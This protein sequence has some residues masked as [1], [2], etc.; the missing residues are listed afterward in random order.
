MEVG[1]EVG[2]KL[3]RMTAP[4]EIFISRLAEVPVVYVVVT[5]V[6]KKKTNDLLKL[7]EKFDVSENLRI[8]GFTIKD[9]KKIKEP[10]TAREVFY[11]SSNIGTARIAQRIGEDLQK[12]FLTYYVRF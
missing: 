7:D 2:I 6:P 8:A 1:L 5:W 11:R 3:L 10:I 4:F 12:E 9:F